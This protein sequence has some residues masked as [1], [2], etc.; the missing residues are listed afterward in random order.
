MDVSDDVGPVAEK[1]NA[2]PVGPP[3]NMPKAQEL[4]QASATAT[5]EPDTLY[6]HGIKLLL[7]MLTIF[8]SSFLVALVSRREPTRPDSNHP[9]FVVWDPALVID[10]F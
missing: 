3:D 10:L 6:P 1:K 9:T 2:A 5:L 4:L 8:G 7:L